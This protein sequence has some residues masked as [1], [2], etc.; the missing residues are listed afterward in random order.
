MSLDDQ[1]TS[2]NFD[3]EEPEKT[4]QVQPTVFSGGMQKYC[5]IRVGAVGLSSMERDSGLNR[6]DL[7]EK[8]SQ[9]LQASPGDMALIRNAIY[10]AYE[11]PNL[12]K[13]TLSTIE[14]LTSASEKYASVAVPALF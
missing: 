2:L 1:Q 13:S 11:Q 4:P 3:G 12:N 5:K 14:T 10:L 6:D 7:Q 9:T 8:L